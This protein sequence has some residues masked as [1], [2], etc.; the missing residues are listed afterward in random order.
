MKYCVNYHKDFRYLEAIDEIIIKYK[1][2]NIEVLEFLKTIPEQQRIILD[3]TKDDNVIVEKNIDIFAAAIKIHKNLAL[4]I[5]LHQRGAAVD[6]YEINIPFF[7]DTFVD[8]WDM[9]MSILDCRVSDVYIVNELAFEMEDVAKIC[10]ERKVQIRTF[11]NVAQSSSKI[12]SLHNLKSFFIR[13][14][15]IY[16]YDEYVDVCEFFGPAD[17][18]SVLYE[19]YTSGRWLGDLKDL[20]IGFNFS[21]HSKFIMPA[22][23]EERVNCGKKCYKGKCIVCDKIETIANQLQEAK[24]EIVTKK[25]KKESKD[26]HTVIE[27][28]NEIEAGQTS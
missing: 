23:G 19:I 22:F 6:L 24:I 21:L 2:R 25:N 16:I 1:D 12:Q 15:D 14:E 5:P 18:Q 9:L 3:I 8:K 20:I 28:T 27:T 11:P 17:R 26:E 13:P 4:M 7:F 10:K